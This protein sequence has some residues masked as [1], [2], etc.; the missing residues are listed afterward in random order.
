MPQFRPSILISDAYGSAGNTTW[1]HRDG[2]CFTRKRSHSSYGGTAAQLEHLDVHRRA[3]AAWRSISHSTQLVWNNL[4]SAVEPHRPPFDHLA[5]I[6]GQNLFVSAYHGFATLGNE[7]LPE[8]KA[9]KRFPPFSVNLSDAHVENG[10]LVVPT[11]VTL[12]AEETPGRYR[13]LAKLQLTE[14]GKGCHPGLLRNYLADR[15]CS[16]GDVS[17][18]I[19]DYVSRSGLDLRQYQVHGRFILLDTVTGYRSQYQKIKFII[20]II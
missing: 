20:N 7:H 11:T 19:P 8:P 3:L 6:S 5:H 9:F 10:T 2:K 17:L 18:R 15:P 14:P 13:L 4:A 12:G 16:D 1:Y